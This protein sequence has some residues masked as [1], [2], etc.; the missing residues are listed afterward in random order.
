M[1]KEQFQSP[2]EDYLL[3]HQHTK[4]QLLEGLEFQS[5]NEDYLLLDDATDQ[6]LN[7]F[8]EEVD[9][10]TVMLQSPFEDLFLSHLSQ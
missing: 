2:N 8:K 7:L 9:K 10:L 4:K 3:F 5:P 6:I 1:L